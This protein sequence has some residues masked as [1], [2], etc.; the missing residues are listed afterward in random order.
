MSFKGSEKEYLL[1]LFLSKNK[2]ILEK[3]LNLT[4]ENIQLEKHYPGM[5]IDMYACDYNL[6]TEVFVESLLLK[7]NKAHQN[8]VLK[9]INMMDKGIIV[10]LALDFQPKHLEELNQVRQSSGKAISIYFLKLNSNILDNLQKLNQMHKLKI[11]ENLNLLNTLNPIQY[12]V[13]ESIVEPIV[14]K[15]LVRENKS[16]DLN[17][18]KGANEYLLDALRNRISYFLPLH[19]EKANLGNIRIIS[20]GAGRSDCNYFISLCDRRNLAFVEL[21]FSDNN[22][23]IYNSIK[24]KEINVQERFDGAVNFK[25]NCISVKFK[26]LK[27]VED[28]VVKLVDIFEKMIVAFSNYTYYFYEDNKQMWHYHAQ[29]I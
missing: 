10:Y 26:T 12:L 29:G 14:A 23:K 1:S 16:Y 13:K 5:K 18:R 3:E 20:F 25:D 15:R 27:N 9:L 6:G 22:S 4:L 7:S 2:E 11:Y 19:R 24:E 21:R 28:T 8:K 17:S